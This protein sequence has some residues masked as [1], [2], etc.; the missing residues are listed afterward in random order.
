MPCS[1]DDFWEKWEYRRWLSDQEVGR[2][3]LA[4]RGLWAEALN[5]MMANDTDRLTGTVA[6]LARMLRCSEAEC[7]A[8][9]KELKE[10]GV[11]DVTE[12]NAPGGN[13]STILSRFRERLYKQREINRLR[14]DRFRKNKAVTHVSHECHSALLCSYG[15]TTTGEHVSNQEPGVKEGAGNHSGDSVENL[16]LAAH[17]AFPDPPVRAS[18]LVLANVDDLLRAGHTPERLRQVFTWAG[19]PGDYKPQSP[20]SLTDPSRFQGYLK[21]ALGQGNGKRKL[22]HH[23]GDS[24]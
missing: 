10:T 16:A 14:Q 1:A 19:Q 11:A 23:T 3:T 13:L 21:K 17:R 4:A 24:A 7:A 18:A 22:R 2:A 5:V 9:I 8:A 20:A 12:R 6:Q 15:K